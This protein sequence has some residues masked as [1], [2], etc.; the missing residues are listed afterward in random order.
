MM[1]CQCQPEVDLY[2]V[3]DEYEYDFSDEVNE[4][5][6]E[7]SEDC[8]DL[9]CKIQCVTGYEQDD[10]GCPTCSCVDVS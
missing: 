1:D 3:F 10:T 6:S 7:D 2:D 8:A 4:D 5:T 9:E